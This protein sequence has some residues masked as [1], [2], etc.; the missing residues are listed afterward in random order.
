MRDP[1]TS[2]DRSD[3]GQLDEIDWDAVQTHRWSSLGI[4]P[5]V[6]EGKQAEVL[7]ERS[8]PWELVSRIGVRSPQVRERARELLPKADR[9]PRVEVM[10]SWYY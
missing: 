4:S 5:E 3:L 7:V 6:K 10:P 2:R 1:A 8:F 9:Q